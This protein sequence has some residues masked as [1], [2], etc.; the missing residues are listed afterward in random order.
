MNDLPLSC[1]LDYLCLPDQYASEGAIVECKNMLGH[2]VNRYESGILPGHI[3]QVQAQLMCTGLSLGY[4]AYYVDGRYF[5]C[6]SIEASVDIQEQIQERVAEFWNT[7]VLP[8]REV[9][10][11]PL[12]TEQEK[13]LNIY[14][15]FEPPIDPTAQDV[16]QEFMNTRFRDVSKKGKLMVSD[17]LKIY[18]DGYKAKRTTET[19]AANEKDVFGNELRSALIANGCDEI[20]NPDGRVIVSYR[21]STN[22]KLT[23]RV[24]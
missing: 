22:G 4:L 15:N 12:L 10:N 24:N 20:V 3:L 11:N 19:G 14:E 7:R 13:M 18:I 8:A 21:E 9:W 23:L 17:D 16:L 5:R 1:T 6:Y 2:V